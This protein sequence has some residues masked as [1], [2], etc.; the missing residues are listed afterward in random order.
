MLNHRVTYPFIHKCIEEWYG[1]TP[2]YDME[3]VEFV[4]YCLDLWVS[5]NGAFPVIS[6][7]GMTSEEKEAYEWSLGQKF[8]SVAARYARS[9]AK[10][11]DRFSAQEF[12]V[13][14]REFKDVSVALRFQASVPG[15]SLWFRLSDVEK[16]PAW[17]V[18]IEGPADCVL[19][20]SPPLPPMSSG[21]TEI[22]RRKRYGGK[23]NE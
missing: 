19:A 23:H 4:H 11:I 9:L 21:E 15:S 6:P 14:G 13:G 18:A 8:Q 16:D 1:Q 7:E 20:K 3:K 12:P 2:P 22:A 17:V 5:E 10:F